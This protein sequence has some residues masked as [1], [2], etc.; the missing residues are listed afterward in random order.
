MKAVSLSPGDLEAIPSPPPIL[1]VRHLQVRADSLSSSFCYV[2]RAL[3][4]ASVTNELQQSSVSV[5]SSSLGLHPSFVTHSAQSCLEVR[6]QAVPL[7]FYV[8]LLGLQHGM[9]K[10]SSFLCICE[11]VSR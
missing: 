11:A 5:N 2:L 1:G 7:S 6:L 3:Y 4:F 9:E 10:V 8:S